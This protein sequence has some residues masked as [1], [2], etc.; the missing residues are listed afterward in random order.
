MVGSKLL[1]NSQFNVLYDLIDS[2]EQFELH[3]NTEVAR[4]H[5][6]NYRA[7]KTG[8]CI[9]VQGVMFWGMCTLPLETSV[10]RNLWPICVLVLSE[11]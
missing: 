8:C 4:W 1:H 3:F 10:L 9:A 11:Y 5:L 7:N 2:P 6:L